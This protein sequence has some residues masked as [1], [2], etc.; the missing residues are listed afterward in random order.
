MG[1]A[2]EHGPGHEQE[3]QHCDPSGQVRYQPDAHDEGEVIDA[4]DGMPEAGE[5]PLPGRARQLATHEV[6]R[7][8]GWRQ[9]GDDRRG[10][11]RDLQVRHHRLPREL[12]TPS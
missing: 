1:E 4:D 10:H 11:S 2:A 5:Q 6:M 9:R 7:E 12:K 8:R 3:R